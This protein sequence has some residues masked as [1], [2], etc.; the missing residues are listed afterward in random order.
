MIARSE[1]PANALDVAKP[2]WSEWLAKSLAFKPICFGC[3]F[4]IWATAAGDKRVDAIFP[5]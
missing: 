2:E 3:R 5:L 4:T 1:A